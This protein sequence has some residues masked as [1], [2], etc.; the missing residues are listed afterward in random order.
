M[1]L[2]VLKA[3]RH[4]RLRFRRHWKSSSHKGSS[5]GCSCHTLRLY[6]TSYSTSLWRSMSF[7][8]RVINIVVL[9]RLSLRRNIGLIMMLLLLLDIIIIEIYLIQ[10]SYWA[11][12]SEVSWLSVN[13][14]KRLMYVHVYVYIYIERVRCKYILFSLLNGLMTCYYKICQ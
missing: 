7:T 5:M 14:L 8:R 11:S 3:S 12:W 9:L 10:C 1:T 2:S 13:I 4:I 6:W